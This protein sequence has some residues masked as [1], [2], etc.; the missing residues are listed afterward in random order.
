MNE[1]NQVIELSNNEKQHLKIFHVN[2]SIELK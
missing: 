2:Q 1:S